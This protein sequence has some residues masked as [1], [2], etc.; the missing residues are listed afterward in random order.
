MPEKTINYASVVPKPGNQPVGFPRGTP[1][2][3]HDVATVLEA[4]EQVQLP[5]RGGFT[6]PV[7]RILVNPHRGAAKE[8]VAKKEKP[9]LATADKVKRLGHFITS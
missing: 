1:L 8:F 2:F 4:C 5:A 9:G 6:E 3:G 7:S